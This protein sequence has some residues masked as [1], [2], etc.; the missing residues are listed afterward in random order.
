MRWK[1]VARSS[2]ICSLGLLTASGSSRAQSAPPEGDKVA[3]EA[4][5]EE[6]RKLVAEG[7]FGDA[8]PKFADSERLDPSPSTLLNLA[9]CWEKVG[10]TATAWATYREAESAAQAAR[11]PDYKAIAQRHA[12]GLSPKLARLTI[13]VRQPTAGMQLKR[14][15]VPVEAS[16]WGIAIPIDQGSHS[17]EASAPGYKDWTARIEVSRDGA[18]LLAS[19]PPLEQAPASP[20]PVQP[21]TLP[22]A[23]IGSSAGFAQPPSRLDSGPARGN[24][25]GTVGLVVAGVGVVTLGASGVLALL[26]NGK[27]ND[28]FSNCE[29]G[30]SNICT[31][32]GVSDR[33]SAL[34]LGDAAT[35][36]IAVGA[37]ALAT[38]LVIW[39]T[40]PGNG[41][42]RSARLVVGPGG[43][44]AV[45]TW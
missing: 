30:N 39:L 1:A 18:Q 5:F 35:I 26:A 14:D 31:A 9:S 41:S 17:I 4:L 40:A 38:G 37:S 24:S 28:S 21:S 12:E 29:T 16:E 33:N 32:Q 44:V 13:T 11:R 10:R 6:G 36:A 2:V 43:G 3:A 20:S 15:S 45:G 23:T 7:K 27:K 42:G 34:G 25:Q 22:A 8:C 19:V